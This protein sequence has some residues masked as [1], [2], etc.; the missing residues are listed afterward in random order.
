[1]IAPDVSVVAS[2]RDAAELAELLDGVVGDAQGPVVEVVVVHGPS[3]SDHV[4]TGVRSVVVEPRRLDRARAHGLAAATGRAVAFLE[5]GDRLI[6]SALGAAVAAL[7]GDPGYAVV[8]G[9]VRPRSACPSAK[10]ESQLSRVVHVDHYVEFLRGNFVGPSCAALFRRSTLVD[11]G[12]P[13]ADADELG[14]YALYLRLSR[15][16]PVHDLGLPVAESDRGRQDL[17]LTELTALRAERRHLGS[18]AHAVAAYRAGMAALQSR[19]GV[20]TVEDVRAGVPDRR[21]ALGRAVRF[22]RLLAGHPRG[23]PAFLG[24]EL[25]PWAARRRPGSRWLQAF[26]GRDS[27]VPGLR[28]AAR[29][30]EVV[31]HSLPPHAPLVVLGRVDPALDL[32]DRD[33]QFVAPPDWRTLDAGA[34]PFLL[35]PRTSAWELA[36]LEAGDLP[37]WALAWSDETCT[38]YRSAQLGT[39]DRVLVAGYF[40]FEDAHATAGDLLVRDQVCAWLERCGQTYDVAHAAP[41]A[42]GVDWRTVDPGRYSHV[43]FA[44]GPFSPDLPSWEL[45]ERF[46]NARTVGLNLSMLAPLEEWNPF[47]VLIERDS[48]RTSRPDVA[49]GTTATRVPVVGICL[50]EHAPGTRTADAVIRRLVTSAPMAAV[51]IDTR[52][53]VM[54]GGTN[55]T[56]QR[57]AA[58]VESLIAR[59][60]V[61]VTTRLHGLVLALKNGVPVVAVDPGNE[62]FKIRR[63]AEA[64]GWPV[65]F[66]ADEV[67]D[68]VLRTALEFCRTDEARTLAAECAARAMSAADQ[69]RQSFEA[70]LGH[71]RAGMGN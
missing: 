38:L 51:P 64:V 53:D 27:R 55:S 49:F 10:V 52:L 12:V 62:G 14:D 67:D 9:R 50:R 28:P 41:F 57:T 34:S 47:D 70:A 45:L 6:P 21:R 22:A 65:V 8:Y 29:V 13:S 69:V 23:I 60:D 31:R 37:G 71:D 35:V 26:T 58:E 20:R 11:V 17:G 15:S 61:V 56:G 25:L 43:V 63:Q 16:A 5:P 2:A 54:H 19:V 7:D 36:T 40:S 44:C 32:R 68:E 18:H 33:V 42:G 30:A 3:L 1:V 4:P 46:P 66:G 24:A 59:M 48:S 39:A